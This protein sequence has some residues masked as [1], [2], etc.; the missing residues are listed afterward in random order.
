MIGTKCLIGLVGTAIASLV[1]SAGILRRSHA[2]EQVV[3]EPAEVLLVEDPFE[4]E[5][6][7]VNLRLLNRGPGPIQVQRATSSCGC[8]SLVTRGNVRLTEPIAVPAGASI[9]WRVSIKTSERIGH[10]E[11]WV[12]IEFDRNGIAGEVTSTISANVRAALRTDPYELLLKELEP[13]VAQQREIG[14]YDAYPDPGI[15]IK[16]IVSTNPEIL[17]TNLKPVGTPVYNKDFAVFAGG[18][19]LKKR[20]DVRVTLIPPSFDN[21]SSIME[22][23]ITIVPEDS[24]QRPVIIPVIYS[25][26][27]PPY[28]LAPK[29]LTMRQAENG[30]GGM[31]VRTVHC[32]IGAGASPSLRVLAAPNYA[33]TSI[34]DLSEDSKSIQIELASP[35]PDT[36]TSEEIVFC[37]I[38][39]PRPVLRLPIVI[40]RENVAGSPTR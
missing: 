9:P 11:Y 24:N 40:L 4:P 30:A 15:R 28:E 31:I 7:D 18:A 27:T 17:S 10:Q 22:E 36:A 2:G 8:V 21:A 1:V 38:E 19:R 37:T 33:K 13:G 5:P 3:L 35:I 25:L 32:K 29:S 20:S 26:R 16:K 6:V 12:T 23:S 39:D 14:I 34:L